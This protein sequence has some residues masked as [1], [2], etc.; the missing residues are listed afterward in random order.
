MNGKMTGAGGLTALVFVLAAAF[1]AFH[2]WTSYFGTLPTLQQV[3][4]HLGFALVLIFLTRPAFERGRDS[5]APHRALWWGVDGALAIASAI[6][7]VYVV[8]NFMDISERGAGDPTQVA[9]VLGVIATLLVLEAT[10]RMVGWAL[11]ILAIIFLIYGFVGPW[12]PGPLAH[13]GFDV[14]RIAATLYLTDFGIGGTPLQVSSTY[15]AIFVIFAAFL[16]VSGVGHFFI[17]WSYAALGWMRGGPAKVSIFASAMMGTVSGSA[18]A[19]VVATGTFTIPIMKRTGLRPAFAGAVEAV[20]SS[21]GQI[22]PPVMGAAAFIMVEILGT[23]YSAVMA[24]AIV[25]AI[26]YFIALFAMVDFEVA[27]LGI[28]GLPRSELPSP[29][30]IFKERW[31]LI[32]PLALLIYLLVWVQ[33]TPTKAAFL[34]LIAVIAVGLVRR[35]T[36]MGPQKIGRGL[37]QGAMSMLEVAA[38]CSCAGIIIGVMMISGLALRLSALLIAFSG[39][40]LFVLM[41]LTMLVSLILGM[42]L[43]T[44]AVYVVLA[45]MVVPAMVDMGVDLLAAHMFVFYFGVLA[46]VTPPVAIAAYAAAGLAGAKSSSTGL[47]AFRLALPGFILPFMWA[48]NPALILNGSAVDVLIAVATALLGVLAL[49]GGLQGYLFGIARWHERLLLGA[50]ALALMKPGITTD[51]VGLLLLGI[52]LASRAVLARTAAGKAQVAAVN[53]QAPQ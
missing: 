19:N 9:V 17:E 37:R 7:A 22:M 2:L 31:H 49:A 47:I 41:F 34:S 42:G 50:G 21:G 32:L 35:T 3:Y 36:R 48:Y 27:K 11:P 14:E 52:A 5:G 45:T 6:T 30:K 12:L 10:R 39:G 24:A 40:S 53:S 51:L 43:P 1:S 18:V 25:P 15:V 33:Y 26:L 8:A 28:V 13:R 44:S 4:V 38:A 46:N 16:D 29:W 23:T 20:A